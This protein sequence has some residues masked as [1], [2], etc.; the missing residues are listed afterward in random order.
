MVYEHDYNAFPELSNQQLQDIGFT[1]PFKQYTEDFRATVIKVHDGDTVTLRTPERDFDFPLRFLNINSRE[2]NEG[3][4]EARE[5]L[6]NQILGKEVD[7]L[8]DSDNRVGKYGR[9]L[10]TIIS[11]GLDVAQEQINLGLAKEFGHEYED[12]IP[13][14]S[15]IFNT[16]QWF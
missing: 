11:Q 7:V 16:E 5:W 12:Q 14:T 4:E 3:G 15:K 1:S 9:L 6:K 8:I 2:L 13:K 10:G